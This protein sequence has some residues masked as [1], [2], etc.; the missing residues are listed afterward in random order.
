MNAVFK[1][2]LSMSF[3]GGLLIVSLL[4]GKRFLKNKISRQWQYYIWIAVVLRLLLPFGPE[5][6]LLGK[7]YQ[8]VGQAV[9]QTAFSPRQQPSVNTLEGVLAPAA[10]LEPD[11]K[12]ANSTAEDGEAVRLFRDIGALLINQDRKSVV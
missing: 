5:V 3:S 8:A 7:T 9:T 2:F 11:I 10:G 12:T 1:I 4:L 6:S